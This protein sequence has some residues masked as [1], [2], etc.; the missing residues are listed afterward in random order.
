MC[1]QPTRKSVIKLSKESLG[2]AVFD[3][4]AVRKV[5]S[6]GVRSRGSRERLG[7]ELY[8]QRGGLAGSQGDLVRGHVP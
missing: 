3:T 1:T 2:A 6:C 7:A 4:A 5:I 8:F